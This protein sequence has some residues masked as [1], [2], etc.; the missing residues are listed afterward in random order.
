MNLNLIEAIEELEEEKG[1]PKEDVLIALEQALKTAYK[2]NFG[3]N[4]NVDV[5]IDR[6]TGDV[7]I[8]QL[9]SVV[10]G[11]PAD[12]S[13][14]SLEEALTI[15]PDAKVGDVIR[16]PLELRDFGRIAV[17]TARQVLIQKIRDFEK[18][19]LFKKYS[20]MVGSV[21]TAEVMR[22]TDR[23]A[24]VRVGKIET[25]LLKRDWIYGE[26][27]RQG[28][29]IKLYIVNVTRAGKS[30]KIFVSRAVPEFVIELFKLEVPEI[31]QGIVEI[32][33]IARESGVRTKIAVVSNNPNVDPVGACIG[34]GGSRISAVLR[35]LKHER[36][37]VVRWS[38]DPLE[39][40]ANALSPARVVDVRILDE[41][42]KSARVLVAPS[43]LSVAIGKGGQNARLA[44]KL[45][46]WKI[47]IK[48][49]M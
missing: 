43:E 3:G 1:I 23:W 19:N 6:V 30:P 44:V 36:V 37:D 10:E 39:F 9:L 38:L 26:Q 20:E 14:I 28:S 18:E 34:E 11:N 42:A 7:K 46:G 13:E 21:T 2:N 29:L 4:K 40:V 49:V 15:Q 12:N 16:R 24:D 47:D 41:R 27:L 17:Q 32:K 33:A 5:E 8:F 22:V 35:E 45:T 31:E 48:A 25:R